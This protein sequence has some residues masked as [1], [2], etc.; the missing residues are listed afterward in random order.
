VEIV[1]SALRV[2]VQGKVPVSPNYISTA[3]YFIISCT[4]TVCYIMTAIAVARRLRQMENAT[5]RRGLINMSIRVATSSIGYITFSGSM[6]AF[7]LVASRLWGLPLVMNAAFLGENFAALMQVIALR[8][9]AKRISTSSNA[10]KLGNRGRSGSHSYSAGPLQTMDFN[11]N[12]LNKTNSASIITSNKEFDDDDDDDDVVDVVDVDT[13]SVT[14][15]SSSATSNN[16]KQET[17]PPS[18]PSSSN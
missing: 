8:P 6:I 15:N 12:T 9:I 1:C 3:I 5:A 7:I 17:S 11:H 10:T 4:L 2:T 18:S 13:S 14:E 16:G